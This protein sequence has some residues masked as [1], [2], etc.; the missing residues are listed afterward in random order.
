MN[1][2]AIGSI[3]EIIGA[4][5]VVLSLLYLATQIRLDSARQRREGMMDAVSHFVD[6]YQEATSTPAKA[7]RFAAALDNYENA[8][9]ED[10]QEFYSSMLGIT[11]G[12][13]TVW[14]LYSDEVLQEDIFKA[15][16]RSFI[17]ICRCPGTRQLWAEMS[18]YYHPEFIA[19]IQNS[20]DDA[21]IRA[22]P[23][24]EAVSA[25]HPLNTA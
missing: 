17:G 3:G 10:K 4:G 2:D 6:K 12:F 21:S 24:N 20:V 9:V 22:T 1:W 16:E 8:P 13:A 7:K 11:V 23:L 19:Y 14:N 18:Q 25:L 5:A 15:M